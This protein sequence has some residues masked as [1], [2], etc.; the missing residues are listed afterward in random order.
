MIGPGKSIDTVADLFVGTEMDRLLDAA[1][2][3]CDVVIVATSTLQGGVAQS[4][5]D[6]ADAV[7]IEVDQDLTTRPELDRAERSIGV[8][9]SSILGA[10]F[11]GRDAA[12]RTQLFVPHLQVHQRQLPPG[13]FAALEP[14][15]PDPQDQVPPIRPMPGTKNGNS[16]RVKTDRKSGAFTR[17][18]ARAVRDRRGKCPL[19]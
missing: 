2:D 12:N 3:H 15:S 11:V 9:S 10:V 19:A 8:L 16:G 17:S 5:A 14:I 18:L 7:I 13:P 6:V 4:L 1:K